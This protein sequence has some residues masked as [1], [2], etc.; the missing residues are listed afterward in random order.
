MVK[1]SEEAKKIISE[2]RVA[3][4]A[5][6]S[7][8]GMPNVS[9]RGSL[10]VLDDEHVTFNES[11]RG[12]MYTLANLRENPQLSAIVFDPA[13][14]H[15]CRIWGKTEILESG[16]LFDTISAEAASRGRT[17]KHLIK[18]AIEEVLTF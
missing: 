10:R 16:E 11:G 5:T 1:L 2:V 13:T 17:V 18:V 7:Q 14:R 6:A 12:E 8:N 4:V 9:P 15:G 3:Q